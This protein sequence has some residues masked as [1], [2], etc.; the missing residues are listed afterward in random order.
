MRGGEVDTT[1]ARIDRDKALLAVVQRRTRGERERGSRLLDPSC[2]LFLS[3]SEFSPRRLRAIKS[4][5]HSDCM[6]HL[7][8]T[9]ARRERKMSRLRFPIHP[10]RKVGRKLYGM[11]ASLYI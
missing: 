5:G 10:A 3:C 11:C 1:D 6:H 7:Q 8:G 2:R 4:I 9:N